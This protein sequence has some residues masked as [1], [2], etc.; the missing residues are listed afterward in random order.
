[1]RMAKMA[2]TE[3]PSFFST[4]L[5]PLLGIKGSGAAGIISTSEASRN[6]SLV[7]S[8]GTNSPK[9]MAGSSITSIISLSAY[10]SKAVSNEST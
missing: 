2:P 3:I 6:P 9:S 5:L 10:G 7:S 4:L 1:M 8:S